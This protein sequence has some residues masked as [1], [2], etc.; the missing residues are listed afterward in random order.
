MEV[1]KMP[2]IYEY[3]G[4]EGLV[5]APIVTDTKESFQ[6]GTVKDLAGVAEISKS[7]NSSNEAHYY[8]NL[9]AV[10][11]SSTGSDEITITASAI[12]LDVLADITGQY[13]DAQTGSYVEKER[14]PKYFAIGYKTKTTDGVEMFVWR[15][16]GTFNIPDETNAT[17]NDGTDANGQELTF[18]GISTIHKFTKTGSSAKAITVD[19]SVNPVDE[20][21]FFGSVQTPDTVTPAVVVPS[22]S[23]VPTRAVIDAGSSVALQAI[24]VPAGAAVTWTSSAQ[25]YATVDEAGVVTGAA[26]GSA[27][28]TA[29]ITV[30]GTNYTD[31][32]AVTVNAVEA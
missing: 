9:P 20:S 5:Y 31:T 28:I 27:T 19:T 16:K 11:V 25:T 30:D 32:C 15:L 21:T 2:K 23:V 22:V 17:E 3:R 10:V 1:K 14:T 6:T 24:V 29:S 8:D 18:T 26:E 7:T 13:Y 4:V 12:P